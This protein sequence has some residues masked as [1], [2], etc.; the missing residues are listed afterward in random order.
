MKRTL[1]LLLACLPLVACDT[2][3]GSTASSGQQAPGGRVAQGAPAPDFS[4]PDLDGQA[5]D[6]HSLRGKPVWINFWATWCVPCKAEMP[7]MEQKYQQYRDSGLVILGVNVQESKQ[8]IRSWV[9]GKFDW[10]FLPDA[11]GKLANLYQVEGV[12][13]HIFIDRAGVI[14]SVHVD[15]LSAPGMDAALA[16]ILAP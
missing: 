9:A 15:Q 4:A 5:V 14:R 6:L 16:P 3:T 13:T 11:E 2:D 1:L 7:L 8:T 10:R 12:P